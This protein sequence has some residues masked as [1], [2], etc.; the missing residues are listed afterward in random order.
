M[1]FVCAFQTGTYPLSRSICTSQYS[2]A[3][4]ETTEQV[5]ICSAFC[6]YMHT[7]KHLHL[8]TYILRSFHSAAS[9]KKKQQLILTPNKYI[10]P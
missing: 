6:D 10:H 1:K 8:K 5:I 4:E 3:N 2:V 9:E 7:H